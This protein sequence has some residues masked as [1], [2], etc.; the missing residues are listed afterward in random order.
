[1]NAL[2]II[3]LTIILI[4]CLLFIFKDVLFVK[5]IGLF[6]SFLLLVE[7]LFL[8]GQFEPN[9]I[10]FQSEITLNL[11]TEL[12]LALHLGLD[13]VSLFFVILTI[14]LLPV[15]LLASW[16]SVAMKVKEFY[17]FMYFITFLCVIVFSVLDLLLFYI[18]FESVLIPM[19]LVIG[20]WGSRARKIHAAYQFFMYTLA[21]S[22]LML[23]AVIYVYYTTGS[24]H[25]GI[26]EN[27]GLSGFENRILWFA[28]F[29]SF[30]VKVPMLPVHIWLPEAHVE[31]PTIGSVLL[32]GIMLKL[33]TYG[34]YRFSIPMFGDATTFFRPFVYAVSVFGIMYAACSTMRQI[35][36][37][38]TIAYSSVCHMNYV[39][40]GLVSLNIYALEGSVF[41]MLS[42]GLVSPALFLCVGFLYERYKTRLIMYYGGLVFGM[43]LFAVFFLLFTLANVSL[44]LTSSFVGE[45]LVIL[46]VYEVHSGTAVLASFGVI[47]GAVYAIW[48][49]NRL[50]FGLFKSNVTT[51]VELNV[52]EIYL[53]VIFVTLIL[54]F[55]IY[56]NSVFSS[57]HGCTIDLL[58][59][60]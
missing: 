30:A 36:F 14:F 17:L 56:P 16:T 34:L 40:L 52:R 4:I 5:S 55:G 39:T 35:D 31:A 20:L 59:R 43:P 46:G 6:G 53:F 18:F 38:K 29:G 19:F 27:N 32:A 1:M 60:I 23:L 15:C 9:R 21:G 2:S 58:A 7:S 41:L 26:L 33:G 22:V 10:G 37:K 8:W 13:G 11:P 25:L 12:D 51:I 54:F 57:L 49:Y 42:H 28:F 47:L 3:F 44:P 24:S 50:V 45:L 48:L